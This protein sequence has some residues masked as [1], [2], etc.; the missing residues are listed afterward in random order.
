MY[1]MMGTRPDVAHTVGLL[2]QFSSNP[3]EFHVQCVRRIFGYLSY[4]SEGDLT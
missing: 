3:S 1:T 2:S 4:S